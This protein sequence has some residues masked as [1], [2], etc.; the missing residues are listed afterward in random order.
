MDL[1]PTNVLR[2]LVHDDQISRSM[3]HLLASFK[4]ISLFDVWAQQFD[5]LKGAL[6]CA[7]LMIWMYY[8][9]LQPSNLYCINFIESCSC[10]FDKLLCA[11]IGFDLSSNFQL[12]ME[13]LMLHEPLL[14]LI[15]EGYSLDVLLHRPGIIVPLYLLFLFCFLYIYL[16]FY[17]LFIFF[18]R[19]LLGFELSSNFQLDMEG[20]CSMSLYLNW[21]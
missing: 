15:L 20:W 5:K 14:E 13:W 8:F 4:Y 3:T 16:L 6:T 9:C 11:L 19:A 18:I 1:A 7:A 17:F 2:Y 21:F 12:D 10:L